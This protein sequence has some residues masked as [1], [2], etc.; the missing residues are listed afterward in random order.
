MTVLVAAALVVEPASRSAGKLNTAAV[1]KSP[2][3]RPGAFQG[4]GSRAISSRNQPSR[5]HGSLMASWHSAG[6]AFDLQIPS[7]VT[8]TPLTNSLS[9][10]VRNRGFRSIGPS[11]CGIEFT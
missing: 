3:H 6:R 2:R 5:Y 1:N 11:Y 9:G 8:G 4:A 7:V 10:T